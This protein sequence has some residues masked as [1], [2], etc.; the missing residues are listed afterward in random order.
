MQ[1]VMRFD[2][3]Y[4]HQQNAWPSVT[5][6]AVELSKECRKRHDLVRLGGARNLLLDYFRKRVRAGTILLCNSS[7]TVSPS[8]K[9]ACLATIKR[10]ARS[11]ANVGYNESPRWIQAFGS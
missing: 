5:F 4:L 8:L 6:Q 9:F 3:A 10:P 1:E 11:F 2:P 7:Y